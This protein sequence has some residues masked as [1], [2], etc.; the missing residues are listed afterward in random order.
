MNHV[1]VNNIKSG[2]KYVAVPDQYFITL[3]LER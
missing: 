2:L 3:N 1:I